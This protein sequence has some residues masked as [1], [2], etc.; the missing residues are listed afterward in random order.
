[1][2]V[3]TFSF[4][5]GK[6]WAY[7]PKLA[8]FEIAGIS[9]KHIRNELDKL[10]EMNVIVENKEDSLYAVNEPRLWINTPYNYGYN[11]I[12]SQELFLL[13]L[14]HAG[15]DVSPI[16]QKLKRIE[17]VLFLTTTIPILGTLI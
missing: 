9:K 8:D 12:R 10:I 11:D 13:N 4:N 17:S 3:I 14:D 5:Y 7:I 1:M 15:I 2:F 6:E 16:I